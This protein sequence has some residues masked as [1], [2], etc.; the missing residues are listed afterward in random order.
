[1]S[2]ISAF[3]TFASKYYFCTVMFGYCFVKTSPILLNL[4]DALNFKTVD[5]HSS[6][7]W[8]MLNAGRSKYDSAAQ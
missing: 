1:M 7:I 5:A 3:I 8:K 6:F 2:S 4:K